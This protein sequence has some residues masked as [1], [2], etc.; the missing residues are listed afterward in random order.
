MPKCEKCVNLNEIVPIKFPS[1]LK[2]AIRIAKENIAD[3]TLQLLEEEKWKT[4]FDKVTPEGGW[5]DLVSYVFKC[6]S[7][8]KRF[9]LIAETYHGAGGHWKPI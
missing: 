2:K 3:N 9:E 1:D 6:N 8:G 5:D 4:P 7:C